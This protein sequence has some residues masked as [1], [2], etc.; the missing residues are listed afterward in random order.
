MVKL[1][2]LMID[3]K[4]IIQ[5]NKL[6]DLLP[7]PKFYTSPLSIDIGLVLIIPEN[8]L[9]DIQNRPKGI[10]RVKYL[11]SSKFLPFIKDHIFFSYDPDKKVCRLYND[12]FDHIDKVLG[13]LLTNLPN[14]ITILI[15]VPINDSNFKKS[16]TQ[17][18]K[19]GFSNPWI[20][21]DDL[22]LTK[23]NNPLAKSFNPTMDIKYLVEQY[24]FPKGCSM[25]IALSKGAVNYLKQ[26]TIIG[27]TINPTGNISQKEMSGM[28]YISSSKSSIM[29]ILD[30]DPDT[31][32]T[33][34]EEKIPV[35]S[36]LFTFH[37]HP[38]NAY[39]N[40]KVTMGW[41]S[42]HDYLG[43]ASA[44]IAHNTIV[45]FVAAIEGI[46]VIQLGNYW[47]DKPILS[48]EVEG[49][50]L[51]SYSFQ[52][53]S[54]SA[55]SYCKSINSI[56]FENQ[57]LFIIHHIPWEKGTKPIQISFP[58]IGQNCFVRQTTYDQLASFSS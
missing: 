34:D 20:C 4:N 39:E 26:T 2:S 42:N 43:F 35:I 57:P 32:I 54:K 56:N 10:F 19:Y 6:C 58:K 7:K 31:I 29:Q 17:L 45:H 47:F 49:F 8:V 14:D 5:P 50:I 33:G 21:S 44:F 25:E 53:K 13:S 12:S 3:Y 22:C 52:D 9:K 24:S 11:C 55:K 28:L 37:S 30:V 36:G 15:K 1:T 38:Q 40:H 46:Y 48:S 23:Q 18:I 41:P 16:I 51:K 27:S